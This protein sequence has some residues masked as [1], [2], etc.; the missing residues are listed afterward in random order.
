MRLRDEKEYNRI[1]IIFIINFVYC[2]DRGKT[3]AL[4]AVHPA[5]ACEAT[6]AKEPARSELME[7]QAGAIP[8]IVN[9]QSTET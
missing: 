6:T 4:I 7:E 5:W 8:T 3:F 9:T 2:R 1:I